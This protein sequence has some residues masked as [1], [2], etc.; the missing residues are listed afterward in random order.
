MHLVNRPQ[1]PKTAEQKLE[2]FS[3]SKGKLR[4]WRKAGLSFL[5][6][7][8]LFRANPRWVQH[9]QKAALRGEITMRVSRTLRIR[10]G[11]FLDALLA[12]QTLFRAN[13]VIIWERLESSS[14]SLS[15]KILYPSS[16]FNPQ[17]WRKNSRIPAN[18]AVQ[19]LKL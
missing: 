10:D 17:S 8:P 7:R 14:N 4:F 6:S 15:S 9:C 16:F 13:K 19:S 5:T 1:I 12:F 3:S 11:T 2:I 18:L